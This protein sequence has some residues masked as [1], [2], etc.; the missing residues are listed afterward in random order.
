[1]KRPQRLLCLALLASA[2]LLASAA[3]RAE[4][5][6]ER[7]APRVLP[8]PVP[9]PVPIGG[10]VRIG[11]PGYDDGYYD[12]DDRYDRYERQ[13]RYER[14]HAPPP[15]PPRYWHRH[16]HHEPRYYGPPPRHWR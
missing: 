9:V 6:F 3:S 11:S 8:I 7:F 5:V 10:S 4:T 12:R 14:R 16:H 13:E 2:S 1:M 15:P